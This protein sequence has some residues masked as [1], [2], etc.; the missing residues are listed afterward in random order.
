MTANER[1]HEVTTT[2]DLLTN[3]GLI[4]EEGWART[5]V[6]KYNRKRI[7]ASALKIKE[8]DYY[9]IT[10]KNGK[11]SLCATISDLGYAAL[12]SLAYIDYETGGFSQKDQMKFLTLGSVKLS[13]SSKEDN[14][15]NFTCGE[16][17]LSFIKKGN[18]RNL[19]VSDPNMVL[20]DG[21]KG[22][23][24]RFQ[25]IQPD[26]MESM[27]IAT[28][29]KENRKAFYLN[30]K[31]NCMPVSG[32]IR[33]GNDTETINSGEDVWAVLDW[34][35][36]RWTYKNTWYWGSGS[37]FVNGHSFGFNIGYG[38]SDRTPASEN[39]IFYDNIVHKLNDIEF[40][41]PEDDFIKPWRFT[42]SDGRFEMTFA[43]AVDRHT[44]TNA[45][46][47]KTIQHQV[48]GYFTGTAI[49]DDGTKIQIEDF[50]AFAEKVYNRY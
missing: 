39:V 29:W 50:P 48:F 43:P 23:D 31:V 49:L 38:F 3:K 35:R 44:E 1:N 15:V 30:E 11:W 14:Q 10:S 12:F 24:A 2:Q 4:A 32:V 22:I 20:P 36:G 5:P 42:S 16:L 47:I 37:G 6:W 18:K 28:S 25:L 8:W 41:I 17:R 27:N 46:V 26:N 9:A 13:P 33:R 45:L 21:R 40:I 34:G 19:L 7:R